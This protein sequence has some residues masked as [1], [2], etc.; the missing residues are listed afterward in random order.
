M[1]YLST[2]HDF[3]SKMEQ[4]WIVEI[5]NLQ[6]KWDIYGK[7][8]PREVMLSIRQPGNDTPFYIQVENDLQMCAKKTMERLKNAMTGF[9]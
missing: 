5:R 7:P 3:I 9:S 1:D 8:Y 4:T 6:F 2:L